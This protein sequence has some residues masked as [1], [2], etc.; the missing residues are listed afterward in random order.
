MGVVEPPCQCGAGEDD[1]GVESLFGSGERCDGEKAGAACE[2][3]DWNWVAETGAVVM[4][5]VTAPDC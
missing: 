1:R 5:G 3:T 2:E 4:A